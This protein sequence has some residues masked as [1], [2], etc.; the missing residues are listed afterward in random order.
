MSLWNGMW[1]GLRNDRNY[2]EYDLWKM[3]QRNKLNGKECARLCRA[4]LG[5][6]LKEY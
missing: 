1:H 5:A 3:A 2:A 6:N 4:L